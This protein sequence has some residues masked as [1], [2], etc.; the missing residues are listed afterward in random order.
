MEKEEKDN[1]KKEQIKTRVKA[2]RG[3]KRETRNKTHR[4]IK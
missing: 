2:K 3:E 1:K 4:G